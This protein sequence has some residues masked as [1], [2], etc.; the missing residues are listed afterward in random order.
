M[1]EPAIDTIR[2]TAPGPA[3]AFIHIYDPAIGASSPLP[4]GYKIA[5]DALHT[6]AIYLLNN[7]PIA[8]QPLHEYQA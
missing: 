7:V 6:K 3:V 2:I 1:S 5:F 8:E 4:P